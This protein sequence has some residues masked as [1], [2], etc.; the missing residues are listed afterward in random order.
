MAQPNTVEVVEECMVAPPPDQP[1][2][3]TSPPKSLPLP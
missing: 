2:S 1:G 3:A